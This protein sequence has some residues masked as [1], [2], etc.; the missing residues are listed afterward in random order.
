MQYGVATSTVAALQ[1]LAPGSTEHG[2]PS[3]GRASI[4]RPHQVYM[5]IGNSASRDGKI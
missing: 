4:V 2:E 3:A 5:N 1:S